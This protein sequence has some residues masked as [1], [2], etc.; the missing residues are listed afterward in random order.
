MAAGN[1]EPFNQILLIVP[2]GIETNS[3]LGDLSKRHAF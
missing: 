3:R 1:A 2:Y